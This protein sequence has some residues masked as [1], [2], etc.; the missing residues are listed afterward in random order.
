MGSEFG[1][2][3]GL[4]LFRMVLFMFAIPIVMWWAKKVVLD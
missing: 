2:F 4:W 1:L 3:F